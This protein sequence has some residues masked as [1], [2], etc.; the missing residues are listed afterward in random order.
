MCCNPSQA[1]YPAGILCLSSGELST[2]LFPKD[3]QHTDIMFRLSL[4]PSA[5]PG[6]RL[7][8][9][10]EVMGDVYS[11]YLS[12]AGKEKWHRRHTPGRQ[13]YCQFLCKDGTSSPSSLLG[14]RAK[15]SLYSL[16][17]L[18]QE[19]KRQA[20][21][22]APAFPN[23]QESARVPPAPNTRQRRGAQNATSSFPL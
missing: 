6:L 17:K 14:A 3:N 18:S 22:P 9:D 11:L 5:S 7:C 19:E 8:K 21:P 4:V 23:C 16:P 10:P 1:T 13:N 12:K 20:A 2:P 15:T